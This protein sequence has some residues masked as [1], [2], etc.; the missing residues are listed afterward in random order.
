MKFV[1]LKLI[2][3]YQKVFSFD[4][5][6]AGKIFPSTRFCRFTPTCSQY[7]YEAVDRYGIFRGLSLGLK[8]FFKCNPVSTPVTGTYDPVI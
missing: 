2:K 8:R 3:G 5:G 1:I 7:T 4:Y 6:F